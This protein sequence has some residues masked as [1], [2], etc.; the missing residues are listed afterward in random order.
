MKTL[1]DV[2]NENAKNIFSKR[3]TLIIVGHTNEQ[4]NEKIYY[5]LIAKIHL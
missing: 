3:K 1:P 4:F 2:S 5:S